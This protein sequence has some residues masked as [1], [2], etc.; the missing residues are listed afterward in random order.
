MDDLRIERDPSDGKRKYWTHVSAVGWSVKG[1]ELRLLEPTE[2]LLARYSDIPQSLHTYS[3]GTPP[4]GVTAELVDVGKGLS[5]ED[6]AGKRV[7]GKLV[8]ASGRGTVVHKEAVVKRGAAGVI[9][10]GLSYEFP[11]V[12]ES[13]DIPDA[14]AY[15]GIW[16]EAKDLKKVRFGFSLSKRQGNELRKHLADGKK[17]KLHATVDAGFCPGS[18]SVVSATI[19]GSEKPQDEIFLVAHLCHPKPS[20]NDNASGSGLLIEVARTISSLIRSGKIRCPRRTIRFLWVPE[21]TGSVAFLARHPELHGRLKAGINLDMVGEDQTLC[22]ST[23]TMDCTPDSLPSYLNDF[24][25]SMIEQANVEYDPMVKIGMVSNFRCARTTYSGGS[26]HAEFNEATV[27]APCVGLTQWPDMF[28]HTSLD[29]IDKVSEDSLRRVG[30]AVTASVL[31]LADAGTDA[32]HDMAVLSSS[33]G[34]KRISEAVRKAHSEL[35]AAASQSKGRKKQEDLAR[36]AM[37]H[38]VRVSKIAA[39]DAEAVRSLQ[40]LDP[41]AGADEF[42]QRQAA[43][44]ADHGVKELSRLNAVIDAVVGKRASSTHS[45]KGPSKTEAIAKKTVPRR[46]FKGSLDST[47]LAEVLGEKRYRWYHEVEGRDASF[48]KKMYEIVNLMDGERDLCEITE[49]VATEYG[50]TELGDVLR[51]VSDLK[52]ARLVE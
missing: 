46:R 10:H 41:S 6:Y 38:R 49:V 17:V 37:F 18:Y 9:T 29:T 21:T 3:N 8:L 45:R 15:Q 44:V 39:R 4:G 26:D 50:P 2:R 35:L 14:H 22:R 5:G 12:R 30:W 43:A 42:V 25:Y 20:A 11:G 28:Y 24:V 34:M 33:E 40:R 1:A 23:L 19:R 16:P 13:T 27:G 31:T 32:V 36:L 48:P 47:R 7:K 51:F 52:A